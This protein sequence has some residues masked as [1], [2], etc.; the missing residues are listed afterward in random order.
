MASALASRK[1]TQDYKIDVRTHNPT[2]GTTAQVLTDATNIWYWDAGL[3][4][5]FCFVVSFLSGS[6]GIIQ[7][8]IVAADDI[9]FTTN[10]TVIKDTGAIDLDALDDYTILECI[11]EEIAQLSATARYIT[12]RIDTGHADDIATVVFIARPKWAYLGH[13]VLTRQA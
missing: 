11:A 5:Q 4:E 13:T 6:G 1:I 7:A 9:A 8:E 10:V 2:T 3:Y 12:V